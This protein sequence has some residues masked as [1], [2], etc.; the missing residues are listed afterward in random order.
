MKTLNSV[1]AEVQS[2]QQKGGLVGRELLSAAHQSGAASRSFSACL[3][4][5]AGGSIV[6]SGGPC[7]SSLMLMALYGQTCSVRSYFTGLSILR[8]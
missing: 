6:I 8:M 4:C 2:W 1:F 5:I 7:A 3:G